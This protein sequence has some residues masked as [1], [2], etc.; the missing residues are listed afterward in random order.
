MK[1][2]SISL[3]PRANEQVK[4]ISITPAMLTDF[5]NS[6]KWNMV[7]PEHKIT[8]TEY[9]LLYAVDFYCSNRFNCLT[10]YLRKII[11][12]TI[13]HLFPFCFI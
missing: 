9:K 12:T 11:K 13:G 1:Y 4:R 5:A 8:L 7:Y 6:G 10:I 3:F 2:T